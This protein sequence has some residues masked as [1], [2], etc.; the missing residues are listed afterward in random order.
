LT[1][2]LRIWSLNLG[3][4]VSKNRSEEA[5]TVT[6]L[7]S[8]PYLPTATLP[9]VVFFQDIPISKLVQFVVPLYPHFH[10]APMT[11]H[12]I[13]GVREHV[14]ICAAV[15]PHLQ[16]DNIRV[17]CTQG[18]GIIRDLDGINDENERW[19]DAALADKRV[20]ETE[21]RVM[22]GLTVVTPGEDFR[23]WTHHGAW[24]RGGE[25]SDE[26]LASTEV[27]CQTL[28][29]DTWHSEGLVYV[30]DCNIDKHNKVLD[31]YIGAGARDHHPEGVHTT[32]S[33]KHPSAKF[34]AKPDRTMDFADSKGD[35]PYAVS[36]VW[37]SDEPGSDH[38]MLM[39]T[40]EKK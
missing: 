26:Q 33:S 20:L 25:S 18:D 40:V 30:A 9:D 21:L 6:W 22:L 10:F 35:R 12:K 24:V 23:F 11:N 37:F 34:G 28:A 5:P 38:L 16:I 3:R 14:G 32:L 31:K 2:Q 36:E 27:V 15:R 17:V 39:A 19:S 13:W 8:L 7:K 4:C 29:D 1:D